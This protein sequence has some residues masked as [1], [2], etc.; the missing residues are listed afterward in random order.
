MAMLIRKADPLIEKLKET[1]ELLEQPEV[2]FEK[3][4]D[5]IRVMD[6]QLRAILM[7]E[8][9]KKPEFVWPESFVNFE[10]EEPVE[11]GKVYI[12]DGCLVIGESPQERWLVIADDEMK[13]KYVIV[14][15]V[16]KPYKRLVAQYVASK[17]GYCYMSQIT[18][19]LLKSY[20]GMTPK[21][22]TCMLDFGFSI[23]ESEYEVR[24][25]KNYEETAT[26][27][28]GRIRKWQGSESFILPKLPE[29]LK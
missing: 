5:N 29:D 9:R 7:S 13:N 1:L 24:F 19:P 10:L 16:D 6:N 12:E 15:E 18:E 4:Y 14:D 8:L 23:T 17:R 25:E 11:P 26:Y 21:K 28:D 22:P 27:S 20:N 2:S 3:I